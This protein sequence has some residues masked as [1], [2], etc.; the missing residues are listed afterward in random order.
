MATEKRARKKA[1]RD[2][3][4]AV[5]EAALRRRRNARISSVVIVLLVVLGLALFATKD[6]GS[7]KNEAAA[8]P[9]SNPSPSSAVAAACKGAPPPPAHPKTNYKKPDDVLKSGVDYGAVIHTSCGDIVMDLDEK[10]APIT[11]N[12]FVFLAQEGYFDGLTWHRVVKDFV[13]QA[14][15]PDGINGHPPDGPG[16]A[17]KDELP[18]KSSAYEYGVVAMANSGPDTGGSQFFIVVHKGANGTA[19]P[20]GLSPS[21]S[22]FGLVDSASFDVLDQIANQE[23]QGGSDPSTADEPVAPV[24]IDSIEITQN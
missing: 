18:T 15:D 10:T 11:T 2:E 13:I 24:Y 20:A 3:A 9:T 17:I 21:Y 4:R 5:R 16:Y 7:K 8:T 1:H 14:G 12:N 19:E 23:T 6:S 22:I